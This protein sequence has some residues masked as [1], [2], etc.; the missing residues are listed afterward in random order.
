M[1]EGTS[2]KVDA[3][4]VDRVSLSAESPTS[5]VWSSNEG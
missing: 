4:V 5:S 1:E 2:N 3:E